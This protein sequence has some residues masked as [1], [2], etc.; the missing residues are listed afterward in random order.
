MGVALATGSSGA[1]TPPSVPYTVSTV[2]RCPA[3]IRW[4]ARRSCVQ[5]RQIPRGSPQSA[6]AHL[7][8]LVNNL[9]VGRINDTPVEV[10]LTE[11]DTRP[12]GNVTAT[13]MANIGVLP[14]GRRR[15]KYRLGRRAL[16]CNS[17]LAVSAVLTTLVQ[18][19]GLS[20]VRLEILQ[21]TVLQRANVGRIERHHRRAASLECLLPPRRA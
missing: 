13:L 7:D 19:S 11:M 2:D 12:A 14:N 1:S 21:R 4:H 8:N 16:S 3:S 18:F 20:G 6:L 10:G 17:G 15:R 9:E 5:P